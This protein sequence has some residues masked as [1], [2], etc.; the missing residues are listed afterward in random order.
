VK[1]TTYSSILANNESEFDRG[2]KLQLIYKQ[3][4]RVFQWRRCWFHC[5]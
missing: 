5:A 3:S 1:L 4:G 2:E